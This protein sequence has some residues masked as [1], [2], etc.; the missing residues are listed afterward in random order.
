MFLQKLIV[1]ARA[2]ARNALRNVCIDD[3]EAK[4]TTAPLANSMPI[5]N[6]DEDEKTWKYRETND[7]APVEALSYTS[8]S[9]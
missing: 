4:A 3:V 2:S 7:V 9:A 8:I 1:L 6:I 5:T